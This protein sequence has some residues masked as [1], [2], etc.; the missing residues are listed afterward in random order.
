MV[1]D[2]RSGKNLFRIPDLGVKRHSRIPDPD[3]QHWSWYASDPVELDSDFGVIVANPRSDLTF[4]TNN[5]K[6]CKVPIHLYVA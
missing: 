6:L 5:P 3:P 2:P 4:L 1:W